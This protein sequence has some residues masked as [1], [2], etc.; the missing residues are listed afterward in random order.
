MNNR[1]GNESEWL[2]VIEGET[3][4]GEDEEKESDD[5]EEEEEREKNSI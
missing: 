3:F 5:E 2:G 4:D 1:F